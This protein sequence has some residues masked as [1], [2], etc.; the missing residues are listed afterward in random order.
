MPRIRS[1]KPEHRQ[2]RKVGP[3]SDFEY[4]LW[5]GMLCEA[6]DEGRLVADAAQL[7]AL[8]WPYHP[9]VSAE[10][11]E[12]CLLILEKS[13]LIRL[14]FVANTRYCQFPSWS[15]HQVIN[16]KKPSV[17]P[18]CPAPRGRKLLPRNSGTST[19]AVREQ[20]GSSTGALPGDRK[21]SDLILPP[22]LIP[23]PPGGRDHQPL[24]GHHVVPTTVA[25]AP[26]GFE[27]FWAAYPRKVAK[28]AARRA[29]SRLRVTDALLPQLLDAIA[30]Q[31]RFHG[32]LSRDSPAYIPHPATW[33]RQQRW[34]DPPPEDDDPEAHLWKVVVHAYMFNDCPEGKGGQCVKTEYLDVVPYTIQCAAHRQP[35]QAATP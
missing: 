24:N 15:D 8:I 29:W 1:L 7:R 32:P 4:R 6:D 2:H 11:V 21:G 17:L 12:K 5:V 14:Y 34:Q 19:G 26:P 3:L 13:G 30:A 22:P 10:N 35:A 23:P 16:K 9:H 27:V 28:L 31:Q 25:D 33:L 20:Y 18:P